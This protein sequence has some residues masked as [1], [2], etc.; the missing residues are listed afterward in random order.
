MLFFSKL[1][2]NKSYPSHLQVFIIFRLSAFIIPQILLIV[3]IFFKFILF[4]FSIN[5]PYYSHK[6]FLQ[7]PQD[8]AGKDANSVLSW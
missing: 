5:V 4:F 7:L 6:G 8:K 1:K 3:N 2:D